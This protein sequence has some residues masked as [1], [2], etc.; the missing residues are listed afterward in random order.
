[1]KKVFAVIIAYNPDISIFLKCVT[2]LLIQVDSVVIVNNGSSRIENFQDEK[3]HLIEL[4]KN[5]GIA[6]AQNRG[7]EFCLSKDADFVLLSDQ[8]TIYPSDYVEKALLCY[9]RNQ[10]EKIA[11]IVP[12]FFNENKKEYSKLFITKTKTI[13]AEIGKE[14]QVSHAIASGTFCPLSIF[15]QVGMMNERMFIDWVDFEWCWKATNLGYKI[16][17]DTNI[18]I[19]HNMGDSF[20]KILGRKIV[21]Y[22]DFRNYFFLRNG[23]WLLYHSHLFAINEWFVF[24][25]FMFLKSILFFVT[26]GFSFSHLKL[27]L[28]ALYEGTFDRLTNLEE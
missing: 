10:K 21:V 7:I 23:T 14:Y 6:Y 2:S 26:S 19:H 8:D 13:E 15:S 24:F 3:I 22:S 27:F 16:I 9:E 1:M 25:G 11:A 4:G 5:M 20:K 18:V 28:R 12:L 17:C